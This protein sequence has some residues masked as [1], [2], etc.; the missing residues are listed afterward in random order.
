MS[1]DGSVLQNFNISYHDRYQ[2]AQFAT[3]HSYLF[4]SSQSEHSSSVYTDDPFL[5]VEDSSVPDSLSSLFAPLSGT[6]Y[7]SFAGK[8][9]SIFNTI[10]SSVVPLTPFKYLVTYSTNMYNILELTPSGWTYSEPT[11]MSFAEHYA[12]APYV[13]TTYLPF[14]ETEVLA[15]NSEETKL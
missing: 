4:L 14:S 9:S 10:A 2:T 15:V 3:P 5:V 11:P 8:P 6:G 13:Y 1:N 7:S 12:D